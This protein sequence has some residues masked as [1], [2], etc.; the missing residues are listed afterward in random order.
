MIIINYDFTTGREI[1]YIE[2]ILLNDNFETNCLDFFSFD[3]NTEV[4]V[5]KKDNSY[6][7]KN[8]LLI[9]NTD[10]CIKEIRKNHNIQ[11]MLKANSF[12]FKK[13][14]FN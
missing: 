8:E 7:L 6:I 14:D 13:N 3:I 12:N 2:G 5:L 11:K 4:K 1:S 9:N 10:Y